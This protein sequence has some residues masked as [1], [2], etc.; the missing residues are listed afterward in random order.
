M[1]INGNGTGK[2]PGGWRG[3]GPVQQD[4]ADQSP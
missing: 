3:F 2:P 4:T 1:S